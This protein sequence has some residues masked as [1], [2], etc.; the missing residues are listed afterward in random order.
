MD[1]LLLFQRLTAVKNFAGQD[2]HILFKYELYTVPGSL[3]EINGLL[4]RE[5]KRFLVDTIWKA[6]TANVLVPYPSQPSQYVIDG[7]SL[8]Q[9]LPWKEGAQFYSILDSYGSF[10]DKKY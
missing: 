9:R 3:F 6:L 10:V 1:P 4:R 2:G 7:G 8:L 5:N